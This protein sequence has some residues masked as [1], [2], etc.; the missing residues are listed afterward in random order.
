[1]LDYDWLADAISHQRKISQRALAKCLGI[2]RD[3]LRQNLKDQ[4]LYGAVKFA[5]IS[6]DE[7]DTVLRF[8]K[9]LKPNSGIRFAAAFLRFLGVRVQ[10]EYIRLSL[11]RIDG[12]GEILRN[13]A[14]I[15][16]RTYEVPRPNYLWHID[17]YHKLIRWGFVLHG[18]ADGYCRTVSAWLVSCLF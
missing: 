3:T 17:G 9:N 1:V 16:R 6:S 4:E 13:H 15:D 12:L 7:L 10:K 2:G 11:K 8:Y 14:A 5:D 18:G